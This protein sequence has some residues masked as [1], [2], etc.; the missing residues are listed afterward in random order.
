MRRLSKSYQALYCCT[1][2]SHYIY[3]VAQTRKK[4]INCIAVWLRTGS[5]RLETCSVGVSSSSAYN[6]H[7]IFQKKGKD[8]TGKEKK[9]WCL[10]QLRPSFQDNVISNTQVNLSDRENALHSSSSSRLCIN[11]FR[12]LNTSVGPKM[13]LCVCLCL[14]T[15]CDAVVILIC[16][17]WQ[18]A[19]T[20]GRLGRKVKILMNCFAQ[21]AYKLTITCFLMH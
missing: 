8:R 2:V 11:H 14:I 6:V 21:V 12:F 3:T 17:I 16:Q 15:V 19:I 5:W 18:K 10:C 4:W 13:R 9:N 20:M 7:R 1:V